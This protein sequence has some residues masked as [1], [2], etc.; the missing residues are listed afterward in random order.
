M[1]AVLFSSSSS[2]VCRLIVLLNLKVWMMFFLLKQ[3]FFSCEC[4]C[5]RDCFMAFY[6]SG[7]RAPRSLCAS[8]VSVIKMRNTLAPLDHSICTNFHK[9]Y[10]WGG[11][12]LNYSCIVHFFFFNFF[13]WEQ[14]KKRSSI[15][16]YFGD[17]CTKHCM[18]VCVCVCLAF[19]YALNK[20]KSHNVL[21]G[22]KFWKFYSWHIFVG[23]FYSSFKS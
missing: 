16:N 22:L 19:G 2:I 7:V 9:R 11:Y 14:N 17:L 23:E 4:L 5:V 20:S 8:K 6:S 1:I 13:F 3:I 18:E 21:C 12:K 10:K 15:L